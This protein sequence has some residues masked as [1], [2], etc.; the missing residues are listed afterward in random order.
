MVLAAEVGG[1]FAPEAVSLVLELATEAAGRQ[2]PMLR[3]S[4]RLIYHRRWW[5]LL[6]IAVQ[7]AVARNLLGFDG[8]EA[9]VYGMPSFETLLSLV[10]APLISR[11]GK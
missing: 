11:L 6:S 8:L 3:R 4:F 9:T 1:R 5:G 2:A 7:R 10:E